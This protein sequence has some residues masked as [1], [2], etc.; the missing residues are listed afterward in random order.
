LEFRANHGSRQDV[1]QSDQYRGLV[2]LDIGSTSVKLVE[3][4]G[5]PGHFELENI[6]VVAV[7]DD[8]SVGAYKRAVSMLLEGKEL[9]TKRVATSVSGR[10]V[11]V[12]GMRFPMLADKELDGA[13]RYEG[14]QVIAFDI[15]E[16]YVDHCVIPS[17][18][19][20]AVVDDE[21]DESEEPGE[22]RPIVAAVEAETQQL[23]NILFVAARRESVDSKLGV[24]E[25]AGLEPRVVGVDAL[26]L[27]EALLQ[28]DGLPETV[29]VINIG[30]ESTSIGIV[31]EGTVPFVRDID[32]A[33]SSYTKAIANALSVTLEEAEQ[34]K[35]QD[36]D[37]NPDAMAAMG[38]VTRQLVGELSRSLMYYQSRS[39]GATVE[40]LFMCG[41]ASGLPGL[42]EAISDMA[43]LPIARWS[44]L[45]SVRIDEARFDG[46][47][48][49]RLS[50]IASLA[51]AL[52]M[53]KDPN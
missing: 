45:D 8:A 11:A 5:T 47:A 52:A 32:I 7:P 31:R 39:N 27:L 6:A 42:A 23:M 34:L 29:G 19:R 24:L 21:E 2:G 50:A 12:R 14:S 49:A 10:K 38:T 41:G 53:K 18:S 16:C 1:R 30:A 20:A 51:A 40:S 46:E 33:G 36:P 44:P 37:R 26:I 22:E 9:M 48:V 4:S 25:E 15:D 43:G 28:D 13:I 3:L 35:I 17:T